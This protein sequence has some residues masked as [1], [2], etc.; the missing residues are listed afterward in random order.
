MAIMWDD[1]TAL[2]CE[3]AQERALDIEDVADAATRLRVQ[4]LCD[5]A[6]SKR[7]KL[8]KWRNRNRT[9]MHPHFQP[10]DVDV[11]GHYSGTSCQQAIS[12]TGPRRASMFYLIRDE[13]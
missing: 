9:V 8:W 5:L 10:P 13:D 6:R 4:A 2:F 7:M 12:T 3:W 1:S 11:G